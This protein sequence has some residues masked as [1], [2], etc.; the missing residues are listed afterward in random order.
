[1]HNYSK[2]KNNQRF[3]LMNQKYLKIWCMILFLSICTI[4]CNETTPIGSDIIG[5][6]DLLKTSVVDSF[7]IQTAT[8]SADSINSSVRTRLY[9]FGAVNDPT[10]GK[11]NASIFTQFLLRASN[12]N[13]GENPIFDSLVVT[14]A[15]NNEIIFGN[16]ASNNSLS[17][18]EVESVL[19]SN[20]TYY[21]D[22]E[23]TYNPRLIGE[24]RNF[25]YEP[26]DSVTIATS[27]DDST[28]VIVKEKVIP[29]LRIRLSDE[30]GRRLM[31]Q[32]GDIAF[33]SD[34]QFQQ[35]FKGLYIRPENTS[36][37]IASFDILSE[38]TKMTLYYTDDEGE[39]GTLDFS[40]NLS[41]AVINHFE[42]DYSNTPVVEVL[43]Q[44]VS[45][46]NTHAY[47]QAMAGLDIDV[48]IPSLNNEILG[49]VAINKAELDVYQ[50]EADGDAL[51]TAPIALG[52]VAEDL[53]ENTTVVLSSNSTGFRGD[54][55]T[56]DGEMGVLYK[57][58]IDLQ[59][60]QNFLDNPNSK[61]MTLLPSNPF[62]TPNRIVVGGPQHPTFPMKL[63]LI[64]TVIEE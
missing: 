27:I 44:P 16:S 53:E 39:L 18:H 10:F 26:S 45:N 23:I 19:Q 64:Y 42:H 30:L 43:N 31:N 62:T 49:N 54:T 28:G 13:I 11:V 29:H 12:P 52:L 14:F 1:M 9:L 60:L 63:R 57:V 17:V 24:K 35:F 36:N 33:E 4:S 5:D 21:S 37:A 3:P 6:E 59:S 7:S 61:K 2:T 58:D 51:F 32:V 47:I 46:S 55:L 50:I 15:Y 48:E 41:T 8:V 38:Q 20:D 25:Q 34:K 56:I 40:M 22:Q